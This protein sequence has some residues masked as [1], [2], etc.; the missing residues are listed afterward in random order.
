MFPEPYFAD[1]FF[2]GDYW[3]HVVG[4]QGPPVGIWSNVAHLQ[5]A[6]ANKTELEATDANNH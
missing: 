5:A 2:T 4:Q 1:S 3:P 6:P